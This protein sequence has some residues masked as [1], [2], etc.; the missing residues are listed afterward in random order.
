[1]SLSLDQLNLVVRDVEATVAF[2]RVLGLEIP[3]QAI[4]RTST[5]AHHAEASTP[6][7]LHL[8]FDSLALAEAYNAGARAPAAA[9]SPHVVSFRVESR[10]AVDEIHSRILDL[11][12]ASAQQPYDTFWGARYAIVLDPDGNFVGVMSPADPAR[13]SAPPDL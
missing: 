3:E 9:S 8:D 7:G 2:Y 13:R 4:W 11:G 12:Y 1:M 10:E 5:G 6:E